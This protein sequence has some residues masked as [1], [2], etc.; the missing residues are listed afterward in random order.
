MDFRVSPPSW[1][2]SPAKGVLQDW[3]NAWMAGVLPDPLPHCSLLSLL[4]KLPFGSFSGCGE[5]RSVLGLLAGFCV[6]QAEVVTILKVE[7]G[8]NADWVALFSSGLGTCASR[9]LS[10]LIS[11]LPSW[12]ASRLVS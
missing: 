7:P 5:S 12:L 10:F 11:W 8:G 2:P 4:R 3:A 9:A 6:Y 1:M